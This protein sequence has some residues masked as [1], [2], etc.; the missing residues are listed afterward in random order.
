[1]VDVLNVSASVLNAK[2]KASV[3]SRFQENFESCRSLTL[4]LISVL[5]GNLVYIPAL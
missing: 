2:L 5:D 1:L 4:G 3:A